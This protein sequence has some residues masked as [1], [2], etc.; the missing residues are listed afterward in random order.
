MA[1]RMGSTHILICVDRGVHTQESAQ[2]KQNHGN[3]SN[4]VR[5]IFVLYL[6]YHNRM[7]INIR[8]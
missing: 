1:P 6:V 7:N 2:R 5:Y 4:F 3:G 8:K